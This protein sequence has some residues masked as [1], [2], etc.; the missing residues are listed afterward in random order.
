MRKGFFKYTKV[1]SGRGINM[2][3][4]IIADELYTSGGKQRV[5]TKIANELSENN[6]VSI[7]FTDKN[8]VNQKEYYSLNKNIKRIYS[9]CFYSSKLSL[10]KY[11][12]LRKM[13]LLLNYLFKMELVSQFFF[14]RKEIQ[15][16]E[17]YFKKVEFDAIIGVAAS[18]SALLALTKCNAIKI[19]W[20]HN[21][22]EA[23]FQ[24]KGR[25][26]FRQKELYKAILPLLDTI[27]VLTDRD[28]KVYSQNFKAKFVR[29]YNPV[30][31]E[32]HSLPVKKDPGSVLFVGRL[33]Y[34][35]KGLGLLIDILKCLRESGCNF[36]LRIVGKGPDEKMFINKLISYGLIENVEFIGETKDV[37]KYYLNSELLVLTSKYEGFGL[38][39]IEA[40]S[41]GLPVISFATEG[42]SEILAD[43]DC[44]YLVRK[45][46][47]AD[48]ADKIDILLTNR[49]LREKMSKNAFVRSKDFS[50]KSII[51]Q[52]NQLL[53]NEI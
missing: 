15:A 36:K 4:C 30:C 11:G 12:F 31:I 18:N 28:K 13:N 43:G 29:I 10:R 46:D 33:V 41:Y 16:Y 17:S 39:A 7:A 40:L 42:P 8:A 5:V 34:E 47:V 53:S 25:S 45:Y 35:Q 27:V 2:R 52:W 44:G 26:S 21:T 24:V 38:V 14:P 6:D 49:E 48:F 51:N 9:S 32:P 19:G 37:E 1:V 20:F 3:I 22:Y 23:Y 50:S